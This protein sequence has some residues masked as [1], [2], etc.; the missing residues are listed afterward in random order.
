MGRPDLH[1]DLVSICH[2]ESRC[3]PVRSH[4]IDRWISPHEYWG[5]RKLGDKSR[6]QG[7]RFRHLNKKCQ[8]P[9]A[10]GGWATH[11]PWGLSAGAHWEYVPPCYQPTNF[12][13]VWVSAVVATQKY[14]R[15]CWSLNRYKG[16]CRS[17]K[18]TRRN[19]LT[20]PRLKRAEKI[21]R[22]MS[23]SEFFDLQ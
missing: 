9:K 8:K 12:D 16:W 11:G 14:I 7:K 3:R 4:K 10:K 22:P 21:Q 18:K 20:S 13:N 19:N 2:R 6:E 17:N 5:Q 23:W 1:D 15:K